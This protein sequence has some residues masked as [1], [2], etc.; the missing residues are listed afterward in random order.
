MKALCLQPSDIIALCAVF[1]AVAT[2]VIQSVYE[3]KREWHVA[4]DFLFH[5]IDSIYTEIKELA[6]KPDKTNHLSYQHCLNHRKNILKH[7]AERFFLQRKRINDA[8]NIIISDLMELPLKI[9]YEELMNNGFKSE[10]KQKDTYFNFI[11]EIRTF[12]EKASQALIN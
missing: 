2:T 8:C 10:E 1:I 6:A 5:A 11:N 9:E 3:R 7:Y 12:T 4:C